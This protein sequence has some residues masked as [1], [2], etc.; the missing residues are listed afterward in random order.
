[1]DNVAL[2]KKM[3]RDNHIVMTILEGIKKEKGLERKVY[4]E[5]LKIKKQMK[6]YIPKVWPAGQKFT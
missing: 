1:M 4:I 5:K 2:A 3:E 6:N